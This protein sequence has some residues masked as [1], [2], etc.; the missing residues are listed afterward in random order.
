MNAQENGVNIK[1]LLPPEYPAPFYRD[2]DWYV[3][4]K[5]TG[6]SWWSEPYMGQ[7]AD[8]TPFLTYSVPFYRNGEFCGVVIADLSIRYFRELHA[9]LQQQYLG[10]DSYSFVISSK[11]TLMYHPNHEYEFPAHTSSLDRIHASSGFLDVVHEMQNKKTGRRPHR[12]GT[13]FA[14]GRPATFFFAKIPATGGYFVL[15]QIDRPESETPDELIS[16]WFTKIPEVRMPKV[17]PNGSTWGVG[18]QPAI[19]VLS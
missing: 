17:V 4:S 16:Q 9:E 11:G 3:I 5:E 10:P 6:R 15:V 13:D 14:S 7:R 2:R 12:R 18:F 8:D 19:L 1:Q